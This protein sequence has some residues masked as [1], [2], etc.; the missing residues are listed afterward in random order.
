MEFDNFA[1]NT[2]CGPT[3]NL[4]LVLPSEECELCKGD[5]AGVTLCGSCADTIKRG[6]E[7]FGDP[8]QVALM[9]RARRLKHSRKRRYFGP[10]DN[11]TTG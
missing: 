6:C 3:Q 7:A 1:F 9:W 8:H 11:R 4:V 10:T 2:A 5:A